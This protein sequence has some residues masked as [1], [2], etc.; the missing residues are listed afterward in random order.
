MEWLAFVGRS[1]VVGKSGG[2]KVIR[3]ISTTKLKFGLRSKDES[4]LEYSLNVLNEGYQQQRQHGKLLV[5]LPLFASVVTE[6]RLR[7]P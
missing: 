7:Q 3:L 6:L 4:F 1:A 2:I 5:T